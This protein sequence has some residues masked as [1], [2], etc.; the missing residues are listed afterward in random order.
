MD[1]QMEEL[2]T[3]GREI[4]LLVVLLILLAIFFDSG[5]ARDLAVLCR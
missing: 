1:R 4:H 3:V 2:K 5:A